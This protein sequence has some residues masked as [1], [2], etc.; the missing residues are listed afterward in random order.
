MRANVALRP[1]TNSRGKKRGEHGIP[2]VAVRWFPAAPP[3]VLP[4]WSGGP[5][6]ACTPAAAAGAGQ[7]LPG[8][9]FAGCFPPTS[10]SCFRL[11]DHATLMPRVG[12]LVVHDH[13]EA[14]VIRFGPVRP[15]RHFLWQYYRTW[16]RLL[17]PLNRLSVAR[18]PVTR[19]PIRWWGAP[20]T[21][22]TSRCRVRGMAGRFGL[23]FP[24]GRSGPSYWTR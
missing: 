13:A 22:T 19:A 6:R 23:R 15:V 11:R 14:S 21:P 24:A 2:R 4:R 1:R 20:A 7:R 9:A 12:A 3:Y 18:S 10:A 5:Q 8:H 17:L 16:R